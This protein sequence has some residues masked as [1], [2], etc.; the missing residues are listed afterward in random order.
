MH[1]AQSASN[2]SESRRVSNSNIPLDSQP[3][4]TANST[5]VGHQISI[6][7]APCDHSQSSQV[8]RMCGQSTSKYYPIANSTCTTLLNHRSVSS[9]QVPWRASTLVLIE[10][11]QAHQ[12][13]KARFILYALLC[14]ISHR[15]LVFL[16]EV[17]YGWVSLSIVICRNETE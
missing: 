17:F 6:Q 15:L 2:T 12:L 7:V 4:S 10:F 11:H 8:V 1:L 14:W 9:P 5:T 16:V 3:E 13:S